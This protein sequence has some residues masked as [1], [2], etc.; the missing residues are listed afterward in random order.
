LAQY[1]ATAADGTELFT[2]MTDFAVAELPLRIFVTIGDTL[3]T[4]TQ[5]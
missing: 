3:Y 5:N 1:K 2:N 4:A